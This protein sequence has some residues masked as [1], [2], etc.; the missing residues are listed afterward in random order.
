MGAPPG[1]GARGARA[2][3]LWGRVAPSAAAAPAGRSV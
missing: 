1:G 3:R 2:C